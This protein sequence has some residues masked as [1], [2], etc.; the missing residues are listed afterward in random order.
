[1]RLIA[2]LLAAAL[3]LAPG[4]AFAQG[5][6]NNPDAPPMSSEEPSQPQ[7]APPPND[8]PAP[9]PNDPPAPPPEPAP[10]PSD[11]ISSTGPDDLMALLAAAGFNPEL[12][13]NNVGRTR[14]NFN[15]Y[16]AASSIY[17]YDCHDGMGDCDSIR[18]VHGLDLPNGTSPAAINRWNAGEPWGRAYLDD[19]DDPWLDLSLWVGSEMPV[20]VFRPTLAAWTDAASKFRLHFEEK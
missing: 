17:F 19:N 4:Y 5:K 1:M 18:F 2:T 6:P 3:L 10:P 13:E 14:I 16:G 12:G 9:P 11:F 8:P 7:P 15:A 20:W